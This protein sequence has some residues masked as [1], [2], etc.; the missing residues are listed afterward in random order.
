MWKWIKR[1]FKWFFYTVVAIVIVGI[2]FL[3]TSPEFGGDHTSEDVSRYEKTGH[4]KE[5]QFQN[6]IKT[7][8]GFDFSKMGEIMGDFWKGNPNRQPNKGLPLIKQDSTF[9]EQ[10][11]AIPKLIWFGHSA[12]LMQL[13]GKNILLD[14]MFGE[15]PSPIPFVAEKRY[16]AALPIEISELPQIDYVFI[17]H[18]HYD[19]LDY[20][21]IDQLK[22]K[23]KEFYVPIGVGAHLR[24]WGVEKNRIHELNWW[25]EEESE[26]LRI[27]FTPSRHFSGRG[28][29]DSKATLW[30]AWIIQSESQNIFF[31]GD[32]GYGDHFKE[33][34]DKYGPFDIAMVECGQYNKN[35]SDI[36]ML[37]EQSAQA[38]VDLKAKYAIPI[39]WGAFTLSLHDWDEP[40]KR[41]KKAADSLGVNLITP[42]IGESI[43]LDSIN[44]GYNIWWE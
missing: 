41:I 25:D 43:L 38:S 39:H 1:V 7:E 16:G 2:V 20:E 10:N 44:V 42:I 8:L 32:G 33:I 26:G 35:W 6:L 14:P 31:S 34:G 27:V 22:S 24:S 13:N 37:P 23:V 5:G 12:F 4:Y 17:S 29:S 30:G 21:S 36:H 18:D 19:H 15:E 40:V 28:I 3:Y 11:K 9:L